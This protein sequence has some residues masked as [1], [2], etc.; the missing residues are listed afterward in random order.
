MKKV[1]RHLVYDT[2]KATFVTS[3]SD[4]VSPHSL[5]RYQETQSKLYITPHGAYFVTI[6]DDIFPVIGNMLISETTE[7]QHVFNWCQQFRVIL[8]PK[9]TLVFH[10]PHA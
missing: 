2:D 4:S 1:V 7:I 6:N 8:P 10:E 3:G 5:I 9:E